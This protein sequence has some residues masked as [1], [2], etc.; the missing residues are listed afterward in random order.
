MQFFRPFRDHRSGR[1]MVAAAVA[2]A[3]FSFWSTGIAFGQTA[4]AGTITGTL[5]DPSVRPALQP[6][7][8]KT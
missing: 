6:W 4:G 3:G 8:G 7:N 1:R 2:F 5:T